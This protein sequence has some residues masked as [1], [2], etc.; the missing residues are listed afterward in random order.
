[1]PTYQNISEDNAILGVYGNIAA[2]GSL[3]VSTYLS[4]SELAGKFEVTAE[5]PSPWDI[6]STASFP[7]TFAG[8]EKYVQ[9]EVYNGTSAVIFIAP[10]GFS[11]DAVKKPIAPGAMYPIS[12]SGKITSLTVSGAGT[13]TVYLTCTAVAG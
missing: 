3:Y 5:E 13:G 2:G 6:A 8:L 12:P 9:V 10:N 7:Y 4:V 11:S 1:M